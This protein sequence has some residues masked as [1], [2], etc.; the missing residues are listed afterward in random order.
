MIEL[1]NN[2]NREPLNG[3]SID[4]EGK[5]RVLS[6]TLKE[7]LAMGQKIRSAA[8]GRVGIISQVFDDGWVLIKHPGRGGGVTHFQS[9]D[10][11]EL[12]EE[13]KGH[14]VVRNPQDVWDAIVKG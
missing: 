13:F 12:V 10:E 7:L 11:C 6:E 3:T 4:G 14:W 8:C 2:K 5:R 1:N 9:G